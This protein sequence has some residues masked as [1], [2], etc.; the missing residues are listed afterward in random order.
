MDVVRRHVQKLR[1][2]ID[3][4]SKSGEGTTFFIK[5]PLTLAIIE[6]LVVL[7]GEQR[8][9]SYLLESL[10]CVRLRRRFRSSKYSARASRAS[11]N[12]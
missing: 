1:R 12:T 2:R 4:Q 9:R 3:I 7:V 5:L 10:S 8:Y 6:G 11:L